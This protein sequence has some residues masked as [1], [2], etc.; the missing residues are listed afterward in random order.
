MIA[1]RHFKH[2]LPHLCVWV[3]L[4]LSLLL[5]LIAC[6]VKGQASTPSPPR[7]GV[8]PVSVAEPAGSNGVFRV[9]VLRKDVWVA[10]GETAH[11]TVPGVGTVE[12]RHLVPTEPIQVRIVTQ[13]PGAAQLDAV[14]LN[15][16]GPIA[17]RNAVLR[18][19]VAPDLDLTNAHNRTIEVTFGPIGETSATLA[20]L[21]RIEGKS[22]A[23]MVLDFPP[24]STGKAAGDAA[25]T[26][27][28]GDQPGRLTVNGE[29]D[30]E[31]LQTPLFGE[32][33]PAERGYP[34]GVTY[35]WVRNARKI[36][37]V[38]I[39]H[40]ADNSYDGDR[41]YAKTFALVNGKWR[42]FKVDVSD[43]KWGR[44]GFTYTERVPYEHKVYEFA[45]PLAEL[46]LEQAPKGTPLKLRFA[47][48]GPSALLLK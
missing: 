35:G 12:L 44:A 33:T 7:P 31:G 10:A 2:A 17:A 32:R 5:L 36:L 1:Q 11:G 18:K 43:R 24:R 26:Y 48:A 37:Y 39:D 28:L 20:L 3:A 42:E 25:Y 16:V 8:H 45:I 15:G 4:A 40:T 30:E 6:P 27:R 38:A 47:V 13:A 23:A 19:L 46:G 21:G 34:Q 9:A 22:A 29:L 41:D 14:L